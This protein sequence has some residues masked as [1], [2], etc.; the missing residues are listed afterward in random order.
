MCALR[1]PRPP[2]R[3]LPRLELLEA[4]EV[5]SSQPTAVEQVFL[6]RLNDARE[7]P[8]AYGQS[9]G[10][11]LAGVASA[12]PLAWDTRLIAAARDHAQD[13]NA[14]G[15]FNHTNPSGAGPG[16]R[17]AA[18]GYATTSWGESIAAGYATPADTLKALI[19]DDGVSNLGH[20]RHLLAIDAVFRQQNAAGIGIVQ[21]GSG[22][23]R[24]YTTIDTALAAQ[25]SR[26]YLMGVVYSDANHNGRYDAS[27]GL[28]G[29]TVNVQ[30]AATTTTFGTGG[31]GLQLSP[32]T[33]TV[34][35]SG[36]GLSGS[37]TRTV[38]VGATNYRLTITA[39]AATGQ[40]GGQTGNSQAANTIS[41]GT[42]ASTDWLTG[43]YQ[44]L[45]GRAPGQ[46]DLS[47]WLGLLQAG[48]SQDSIVA[49]IMASPEYRGKDGTRW[50]GQVYQN[51]LGRATGAA[52]NAYW[53]NVLQTT[54]R[55]S[56]VAA[57]MSSPE[58]RRADGARWLPGAYQT[59][60]GREPGAPDFAYW[61]GV[62]EGGTTREQVHAAIVS[63]PEFVGKA[64]DT[65]PGWIDSAYRVLLGR[66]AGQADLDYWLGQLQT[67]TPRSVIADQIMQSTEYR[68][69]D[70]REWV[71]GLYRD[72]LGR[73][74]R[75]GDLAYWVG[76]LQAGATRPGVIAVFL[77]SPEF[78]TRLASKS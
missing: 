46:A 1:L 27:E 30:G 67:G 25:D 17:M 55:E 21:N 3:F 74:P 50:L 20:R 65:G 9:I 6:E 73:E 51:L 68:V 28:S 70:F 31:Y 5:L 49:S 40:A 62:L 18:V 41:T 71:A 39:D 69:R 63:S 12:Q 77:S 2:R 42:N 34:V 16:E 47:F 37:V 22:P 66:G 78:N 64:A 43:V 58:Y 19:V 29:V 24:D 15:F 72:L 45:L 26:P 60:L 56:V 38:S 52:D 75:D 32:G 36:G 4:R 48:S 33:Y 57:I 10:L 23:F 44:N 35:F 54:P 61:L 76:A 13:M 7:N 59:L 8:A 14:R 11:N 53:L